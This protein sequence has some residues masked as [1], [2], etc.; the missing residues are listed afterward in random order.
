LTARL[1]EKF[2]SSM[3]IPCHEVVSA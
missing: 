1:M 2:P 3:F